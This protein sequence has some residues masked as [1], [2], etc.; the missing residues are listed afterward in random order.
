[1]SIELREITRS[2]YLDCMR[3]QVKPEQS[4]FIA[5]NTKS[6]A[7]SK[8]EPDWFPLAAYDGDTLVGFTMYGRD[9]EEGDWWIIRVMVDAAFQGRGYG[10]AITER[11]IEHMVEHHSVRTIFLD[12]DPK[13]VVAAKL[14]AS[15][16]F[17]VVPSSDPDEVV[18]RLDIAGV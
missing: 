10:R 11:V 2:N 12:Y 9:D 4:D 7:Q 1:M 5:S 8:Y 6:L 3:L 13:N 16:G 15:L 14:Y 18:A 17:V